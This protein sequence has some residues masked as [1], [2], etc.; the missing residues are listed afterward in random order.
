MVEKK[1]LNRLSK[2]ES[3]KTT[4]GTWT[5]FTNHAHVMILLAQYPEMVLREVAIKVGITERAVQKI[6]ADLEETSFIK[7]ERV[8]RSNRYKLLLN[9]PLRHPIE[10]HKTAKEVISLINS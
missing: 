4:S 2:E 1:T 10:A 9:K 7:K 3:S 6:V 8:G 5:F